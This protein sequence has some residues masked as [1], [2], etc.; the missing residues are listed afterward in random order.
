MLGKGKLEFNTEITNIA[1]VEDDLIL[2]SEKCLPDLLRKQVQ[3]CPDRAAVVYEQEV[4]TYREFGQSS[5]NLARYLQYL[6]VAPDDCIGVFT[7]PSLELMVGVWGIL[8]SGSA[9][10]PLSPEY[11]RER[12]K[13]MVEDSGIK[14][15]FSQ[16]NLK[17]RLKTLVPPEMIIVTPDDV[18]E[19]TTA[20]RISEKHALRCNLSKNNL[21]YI[22]YTSGSTGKPKG[23]MIEHHSIVNQMRW[24][25]K[26]FS[27]NHESIVL[28]KTPMSFDAAQWEILAP[29][30]GCTVV[31]GMPGI[32]RD[33]E[34]LIKTINR[35]RVTT[36]QC[37][38]TLLQEL[39][40]NVE[41]HDCISLTKIFSGGEI[42]TRNLAIQCFESLP[43]C[44]LINL[45][46]PTECTIN[47]F[48]H[49]LDRKAVTAGPNSISIGLPVLNTLYY[50]L[51][52]KG[53]QTV[54]GEIGELFIGGDQLARGYLHKPD[55]TADKFIGNPFST[56][57]TSAKLYRT[58][59]LAFRETD[60]TVQF[61][62]R[63]DNQIKLRGFRIELDEIRLAIE[64]HSWVKNSVMLIKQDSRT[65]S[66]SLISFI[67]LDQAE[68]SLMDQ[69]NHGAHHQS[70]ESKFQ[71]K[72]QLLNMGCR[73]SEEIK[74]KAVVE[75]LGK[76]PGDEQRRKVFAR[77][78]YRFFE[79]GNVCKADIVQL[80]VGK[81]F[82]G[83]VP[84]S[85]DRLNFTL[86]SEILRYFGQFLSSERLLPKYGYASP[87]ALYATQMYL[88][89]NNIS[90][91][92]HGI[93]YYHP[94][95]H[96]LILVKEIAVKEEAQIKIHFLG[97]KRAIESV[98]KNNIREVLEI[99]T[100]HMLGLFDEVLPT[101]GL[102]IGIGE[103]SPA[104][105]DKLECADEDY[106]IGSFELE[107]LAEAKSE[108]DPDIYVQAHLGKVLDLPAGQY[109]FKDD[110]FEKISDKLILKK[111]VIAINQQVYEGASFGISIINRDSRKWMHYI[112]LGRKL[113]HLQMN[114]L[115]LGLM[116]SGYSSKT[117][118]D[119]P[120]AKRMTDILVDSG[121]EK[122]DSFYF[123]I[124]GR[125]SDVQ[126]ESKGMKEDTIHMKGPVEMIK[127]DLLSLLP[128]YMV[129]NK[130][131]LIDKL[132][133]TP[134][135]KIDHN[136]LAASEALNAESIDRPFIAPRTLTEERLGE[137]WKVAMKWD[138]VS[139]QD[140]FFESGGDS[141]MA[142]SMIRDIN[143][144]FQC[145]LPL[146]VLFEAPTI[147]ELACKVDGED[148]MPASRLV[149]LETA[150][151][152]LPVYCWP[153]LG[154]YPM[155]LKLLANQINIDRPFYGIQAHGINQGETP[156]PT[157]REMAEADIKAIK[158]VQPHGPYMLWGYSFGARLAFEVAYQLEQSGE[159]IDNLFLIAPGSPK[160][161]A[162]VVSMNGNEPTFDNTAFVTILFSVFA[163]SITSPALNECLKVAKDEAS[164]T[165]FICSRYKHL[166]SGLVKRVADIVRETYE[167]KYSFRELNERQINAPITIFKAEGDDYSFLEN[168]HGYSTK[169]P[170]VI[171]LKSD[172]YSL[173]KE[174]GVN[175]LVSIIHGFS[176]SVHQK[177]SH[178]LKK[179]RNCMPHI[180]IKYFPITLD[181][182]QKSELA[183]DLTKVVQKA[184]GCDE[185]LI[186]IAL[187]PIN[188]EL[189]NQQVYV[190][191]IEQRKYLLCKVPNY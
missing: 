18:A 98:Y 126:R 181:E 144:K 78:T 40:N 79:G 5:S 9:Y 173:L 27:F 124:G 11:P 147:E 62:G 49:I 70:K 158:H 125:I 175:E 37:V 53:S 180:N 95:N 152:K 133:L 122:M 65:K 36:L 13:F 104:I 179:D 190:P 156:F 134:N 82:Q 45:Y 43:K 150:G 23:V 26:T 25:Q 149:R 63:A 75:L 168:S 121:R 87:G 135:G 34:G 51:D 187:E 10:L 165:S 184:F 88:E 138:A 69:G 123:C 142:V 159:R 73:D 140:D 38:P 145:S 169:A 41:F 112:S 6:G 91:L 85:L 84:R 146:Q 28:Q 89:L 83:S 102:G 120:S 22:I 114:D 50:I 60:G 42:L 182:K 111:H 143:K 12:L 7:N 81:Q 113:Q 131:I 67:E 100:G 90:N 96:Q 155:N 136:A 4:L 157:I 93:Y 44:D 108:D 164:F 139:V 130:I 137:I 35:Y 52:K 48:A 55:L 21:A 3:M 189:W 167:F 119:L 61:S 101:Y 117:G 176:A 64:D 106:Y 107:S 97:K 14:I 186:S 153:G 94:V 148:D 99:E 177:N 154:G 30:F 72:A 129:P 58:G 178:A 20:H 109:Q 161:H 47:T 127:E 163:H 171:N 17:A 31:M 151:N 174:S 8:F 183:T 15:I 188:S 19:F 76:T 57:V 33:L 71:V 115:N 116:S 2:L 77:K 105:K 141:L 32:Y 92:N 24:L 118:N 103:F 162:H 172:H 160:L 16:N 39:L 1:A 185:N 132:P 29:C 74:G 54:S 80:L 128:S 170:T 66:K 166:D 68:A 191:E 86:L 59:D 56:D 46:G 110:H